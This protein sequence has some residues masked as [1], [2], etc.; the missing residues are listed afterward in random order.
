[1]TWRST[2]S[3]F[4]H[5]GGSVGRAYGDYA[6]KYVRLKLEGSAFFSNAG[7]PGSL[8]YSCCAVHKGPNTYRIRAAFL[9]EL[10]L[11]LGASIYSKVP[12]L[13]CE[14]SQSCF[15]VLGILGHGEPLSI[16]GWLEVELQS[17]RLIRTHSSI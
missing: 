7:R 9:I 11:C 4:A 2:S 17:S 13:P 3:F 15:Q 14:V 1:M 5:V 16:E 12:G 6:G 8:E 10:K